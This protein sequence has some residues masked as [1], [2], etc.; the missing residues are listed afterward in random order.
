MPR[1]REVYLGKVCDSRAYGPPLGTWWEGAVTSMYD[2]GLGLFW[3]GIDLSAS[4]KGL[5][6]SRES[7]TAKSPLVSQCYFYCPLPL[8]CL[9]DQN[10]HP[11]AVLQ[12]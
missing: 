11:S 7:I 3:I 10:V 6:L 4:A 9:R 5:G 12:A 8:S 2:Y 1:E